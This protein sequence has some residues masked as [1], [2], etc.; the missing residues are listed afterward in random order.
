[1][2]S[3]LIYLLSFT[4]TWWNVMRW[5][6]KQVVTVASRA[7]KRTSCMR[8]EKVTAESQAL[9]DGFWSY[10]AQ[11]QWTLDTT[12]TLYHNFWRTARCNFIK[13]KGTHDVSTY[14]L[15]FGLDLHK[16]KGPRSINSTWNSFFH[17]AFLQCSW[18]R[19]MSSNLP[20]LKW[21]YSLE[22]RVLLVWISYYR[23]RSRRF[24]LV[25]RGPILQLV[26]LNTGMHDSWARCI[27]LSSSCSSS[28][29]WDS[30]I[31]R[32]FLGAGWAS[33]L[34]YCLNLSGQL[35]HQGF[36]EQG[37]CRWCGLLS[38]RLLHKCMLDSSKSC[39]AWNK[40]LRREALSKD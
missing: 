32:L 13:L 29:I 3:T 2:I 39:V 9:Q 26:Y 4:E 7:V 38:V 8:T 19:F 36:E 34:V 21:D 17:L 1:M 24:R 28:F 10:V 6:P 25:Y 12:F 30:S 15:D 16:V 23:P 31:I 18:L 14:W 35:S 33:W 27:L 40:N 37:S 5:D 22:P 11:D 20:R